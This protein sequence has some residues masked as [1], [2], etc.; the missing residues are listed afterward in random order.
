MTWETVIGLE[1]HAQLLTQTK[2]FCACAVQ[3][4]GEPNTRTCPVCLGLPGALPVL[5][6]EVVRL[7]MRAGLATQ[8]EIREVSIFA[9]KNYFY[10]DLPKGYQITQADDPLCVHGQLT[11]EDGKIARI[12]R[13][14]LEE[15]A[16]KSMHGAGGTRVDLNRAGTPL[17]EIVG[18]PDLR[19]ADE[20]VAYLRELRGI[21]V[22]VGAC[23]GNMEAGSLR[24]DANVSVRPLGEKTLG[25]RVEI[26][27]MNSFRSVKEAIQFEVQRQID[28]L[29]QGHPIVQETRLW[30]Q[31]TQRTESMRSKEDAADYRY[32]PDPDLLPLRVTPADIQRERM[33]LP[34]LPAVRKQRY[35][36][37]FML[38]AR[39]IDWL[40]EE[41]QRALAFDRVVR[42]DAKN[43]QSFAAFLMSQVQAQLLRQPRPW[44]EID[45]A[46]PIFLALC[47]QW[48]AGALTNK[49]LSDVLQNALADQ[50]QPLEKTLEAALQAVGTVVQDD[51]ALLTIV[52]QTLAKFPGEV[53]KF[54][55]GQRQIL[56]F[57]VGQAMRA[58]N[59]KGDAKA[60]SALLIQ[61]LEA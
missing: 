60:I 14:H 61:K 30:D 25:T 8:C 2:I 43:A 28:R 7:A 26:K 21:L 35:V 59:G 27:N 50:T 46:M 4:G 36:E 22:T 5:N 49:M 58:L 1:V 3:V 31:E 13:I 15:D 19:S 51:A 52:D 41:P 54:R 55:A 53:A 24:C 42:G 45:V 57:L 10:P 39:Q 33:Q 6:A 47:L 29:Q 17:I 12:L 11:L 23:D 18:Q 37:E 40:S 38:D 32:F 20:A 44:T 9:R 16:G 34:E 56:G 48:K